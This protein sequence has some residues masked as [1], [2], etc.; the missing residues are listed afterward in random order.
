M[1]CMKEQSVKMSVNVNGNIEIKITAKSIIRKLYI[2][3]E[4]L[5]EIFL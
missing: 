5:E 1:E 3:K 2:E 4:K